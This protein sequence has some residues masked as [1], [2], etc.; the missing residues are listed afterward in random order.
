MNMNA[1][2]MLILLFPFFVS[3]IASAE[4]DINPIMR[5]MMNNSNT[6][7]EDAEENEISSNNNNS[8]SLSRVIQ[9][10]FDAAELPLH[11]TNSTLTNYVKK[12]NY[13]R[14]LEDE[15]SIFPS[16]VPEDNLN[17]GNT[18]GAGGIFEIIQPNQALI[19]K[20][21][22]ESEVLNKWH[23]CSTRQNVRTTFEANLMDLLPIE[24][25]YNIEFDTLQC[26]R[27]IIQ[28][29]RPVEI[30]ANGSIEVEINDQLELFD[31]YCLDLTEITDNFAEVGLSVIACHLIGIKCYWNKG[32][33]LLHTL[34]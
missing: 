22:G 16:V 26:P 33:I 21:C 27:R 2:L 24:Q 34:L 23:Q 25:K 32:Q 20:C 9:E 13:S 3:E 8:S 31:D 4:D 12:E 14:M 15:N 11:L 17:L 18:T 6:G 19:R 1:H 30:L 28:E 29:Y 7:V 10:I 5:K